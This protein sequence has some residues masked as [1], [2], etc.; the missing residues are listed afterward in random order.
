[1]RFRR[2]PVDP[3]WGPRDQGS[4]SLD[5][6][7]FDLKPG[8][9]GTTIRLAGSD[10]YQD[11]IAGIEAAEIETAIARRTMEE[12]RTDAPIP[13]RL[14]ADGRVIGPVGEVPR[15]LEGPV[16]EAITRLELAGRRPRIPVAVV[17]TRHGLRVDL[18]M[19]RTR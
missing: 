16:S 19:G 2:R 5:D 4:G 9:G 11:L 1:M 17:S 13:V 6:Y 8:S 7:K 14:F 12:E 3:R 10:Q 18:L 15:G